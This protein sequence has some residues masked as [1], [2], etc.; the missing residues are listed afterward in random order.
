[1]NS[2]RGHRSVTHHLHLS[3]VQVGGCRGRNSKVDLLPLLGLPLDLSRHG[4]LHGSGS[5]GSDSQ[6]KG[7]PPTT[8][9]GTSGCWAVH[10]LTPDSFSPAVLFPSPPF[11][12]FLLQLSRSPSQPVQQA[13]NEARSQL[14]LRGRRVGGWVGGVGG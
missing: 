10:L 11:A 12:G 14:W 3:G 7:S 13:L 5:W 1:M 4:G 8:C 9:A 6:Q 2:W